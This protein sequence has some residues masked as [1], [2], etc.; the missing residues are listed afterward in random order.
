MQLPI[1]TTLSGPVLIPVHFTAPVAR[2]SSFHPSAH[3]ELAAAVPHQHT[4][5]HDERRHRHRLALVDVAERR[6]PE[7]LAAAGVDCYH[8]VVE[9]RVDDLPIRVR[10]SAI[11]HVATR[12]ALRGRQRLRVV[13]PLD[14][15]TRLREIERV[16]QIRIRR[17]H[18][19][20]AA[21]DQRRR[22]LAFQYS[23]GE[24]PRRRE[25][26]DVRRRDLGE[27][28]IARARE[29]LG[30]ADPLAI[31]RSRRR[32]FDRRARSVPA[33]ACPFISTLALCPSVAGGARRASIEHPPAQS[34]PAISTLAKRRAFILPARYRWFSTRWRISC[35][36]LDRQK[37]CPTKS[38]SHSNV[39]SRPA[40]ALYA[41]R[42]LFTMRLS[43]SRSP[44]DRPRCLFSRAHK[45]PPRT[46]ARSR[47]SSHPTHADSLRGSITPERAWWDATFYDLHVRV[48]P[49]DS[50]ISGSR[51]HHLR[52]ARPRARDADRSA[53]AA[54]RRQHEAGPA[55]PQHATRR[56]RLLRLAPRSAEDRR[57]QDDPRLLSRQAQRSRSSR[58][59]TAVSPGRATRST[60]H[61]SPPRI[62]GSAPASGGPTRTRRPTSRTASASPS[63]SPTR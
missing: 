41:C 12:L 36:H 15:R 7:F 54:G 13:H 23:S 16:Q 34:T 17:H 14:R 60:R 2:S 30:R 37:T 4:I 11:H 55:H 40:T 21:H 59:G 52:R 46:R 57:A 39:A 51:R 19:H 25:R 8:V 58:R 26:R 9:R 56:Q 31:L 33:G 53:G 29:V 49:K 42:F 18:V 10:G 38:N 32:R 3:A 24:G 45:S 1:S 5:L 63:P 47:P 62:K 43:L 27:A 20:G 61:G 44:R 50:S 28:A 6:A 48:S 35:R 22:L